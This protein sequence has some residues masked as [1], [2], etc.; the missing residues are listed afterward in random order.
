MGRKAVLKS[1]ELYDLSSVL[2]A[3]I[4]RSPTWWFNRATVM[5]DEL[6]RKYRWQFEEDSVVPWDPK[7]KAH[8]Y[9]LATR[10]K[11]L[12][13]EAKKFLVEWTKAVTPMVDYQNT[14]PNNDPWFV[15]LDV[16]NLPDTEYAKILSLIGT[17]ENYEALA[18]PAREIEARAWEIETIHRRVMSELGVVGVNW[19]KPKDY[20]EHVA[21]IK[22]EKAAQTGV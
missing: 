6:Y 1:N 13:Y 5:S 12:H 7:L 8:L 15:P 18:I 10:S 2:G 3:E 14:N 17:A 19:L 11:K 9:Y 4:N 22:A 16:Q 21:K 20:L